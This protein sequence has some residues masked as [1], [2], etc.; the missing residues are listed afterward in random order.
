MSI[1][2][3]KGHIIYFSYVQDYSGYEE[4]KNIKPEDYK[5]SNLEIE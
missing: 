3:V 4:R 2:Q 5:I 1:V